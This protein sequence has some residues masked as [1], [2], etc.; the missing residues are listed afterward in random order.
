MASRFWFTMAGGV[1]IPLN[2]HAFDL[3]IAEQRLRLARVQ[4]VW[5]TFEIGLVLG[6]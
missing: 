3:A 2:P 5:P 1:E 4:A 6:L